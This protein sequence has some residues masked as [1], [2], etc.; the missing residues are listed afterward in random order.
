MEINSYSINYDSKSNFF[1]IIKGIDEIQLFKQFNLGIG[2]QVSLSRALREVIGINLTKSGWTTNYQI[3]NSDR[4]SKLNWKFEYADIMNNTFLD[5]EVGHYNGIGKKT[6]KAIKM[7]QIDHSMTYVIVSISDN[8]KRDGN[9][10]NSASTARE[11]YNYLTEFKDNISIPVV[12]IELVNLKK[13]FIKSQE[14]SEGKFGKAIE[15]SN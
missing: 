2:R 11:I 4:S 13:F 12:V 8:F 5:V 14:D 10:D 3:S 9:F 1:E 7:A 15:I 6:L